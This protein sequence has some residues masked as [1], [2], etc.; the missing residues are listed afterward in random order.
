MARIV[1]T[2]FIALDGVI[3]APGGGE[4]FKHEAWVFDHD[5]G[6]EGDD[7]KL[8][9]TLNSD[10]LLLGRIT[11]ERFAEAWPTRDGE[12]ADKFNRM[13]KYVVSSTLRDPEWNNTTVIGD[14]PLAAAAELDKTYD[15]D[16]V[17]HG[18]ARLTQTL[19]DHDL[20]DELRLML[21]PVVL[22]TGRRLFG[23][24]SDKKTLKL[25]QAKAVGDGIMILTYQSTRNTETTTK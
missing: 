16:V 22:G 11:Y 1:A 3:E 5:R 24:T 23:E 13:P 12:F 17:I 2:E 9:E 15:G 25:S 10:A 14:D 8:H 6:I 4:G 21:F 18:S 20:I 7:F 19:L